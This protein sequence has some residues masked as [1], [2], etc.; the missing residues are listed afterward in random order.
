[1]PSVTPQTMVAFLLELEKMA[2]VP[3][4]QLTRGGLAL[5]AGLTGGA[6]GGMYQ[7]GKEYRQAR[8]Q[9]QGRVQ[10]LGAGL[11]GGL[12]GGTVGGAAGAGLAAVAPGMG[13]KVRDF[14]GQMLHMW[15]GAGGKK[16]MEAFGGGAASTLAQKNLAKETLEAAH[17]GTAKDPRMLGGFRDRVMGRAP[18]DKAGILSLAEKEHAG[19]VKGH[20]AMERAQE[21]GLTSL[22]GAAKAIVTNPLAAAKGAYGAMVHG[23]SPAQQVAAVG[24]P[25]ALAAYGALRKPQEGETRMGNVAGSVLGAIPAALPMMPTSIALSMLPGMPNPGM[26]ASRAMEHGGK[27]VGNTVQ[28]VIGKKPGPGQVE[29]PPAGGVA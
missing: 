24:I 25:G 21:L 9:G 10:A 16:G 17:A 1:M 14:G 28:R 4:A 13:G 5:G 23:A 15:T 11:K 18:I 3:T 29:P 19:A 6:I 20:A 12:K 27:A 8:E 7:G 26:L 22:P 2:F